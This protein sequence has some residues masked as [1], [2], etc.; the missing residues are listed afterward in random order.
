MSSNAKGLAGRYAGALYD[1]A[2]EADSVDAVLADLQG[3]SALIAD[4]VDLQSVITSP[5][6]AGA[7]QAAAVGAVLEKAGANPLSIKFVG[8]VASNGRL[9]ALQHIISAFVE[10]VA[11]RRGQITA[12]VVSAVE[13][14]ASR[15][16]A[17]EKTV[18][19]LAGADTVSLSM[20]VDPSLIG[21]LIVRIGSRM[22]D[23]SIKTKLNRLETAMKG[24]A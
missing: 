17:V 7:E 20:R 16:K 19:E 3:L 10:M 18:A 8:A 22:F 13:L 9:F 5:I 24:V 12:E 2:A 14:D 11:E 1:L 15:Q 6:Y 23:T 21:G 4:H